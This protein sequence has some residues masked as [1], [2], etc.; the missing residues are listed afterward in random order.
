[1]QSMFA[2]K[3][4][5]FFRTIEDNNNQLMQSNNLSMS[6]SWNYDLANSCDIARRHSGFF[7]HPSPLGGETPLMFDINNMTKCREVSDVNM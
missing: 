6:G 3:A 1:M 2:G 4:E 7:T 5:D